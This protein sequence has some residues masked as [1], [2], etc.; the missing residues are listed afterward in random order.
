[1]T[2]GGAMYRRLGSHGVVAVIACLVAAVVVILGVRSVVAGLATPTGRTAAPPDP[3][4]DRAARYASTLASHRQLVDGRSL[5]F[6]PSPPPPPAP[7]RIV[8]DP[9]PPPPPPPPARYGGPAIIAMFDNIVWFDDGKKLHPGETSDAGVKLIRLDAPWSATV[10]WKGVEFTVSF[11]ERDKV[12]VK[13][14]GEPAL[15]GAAAPLT[16]AGSPEREPP[17]PSPA[18]PLEDPPAPPQ[19][20]STAEASRQ[21]QPRPEPDQAP[22]PDRDAPREAEPDPSAPPPSPASPTPPPPPP[23]EE[24]PE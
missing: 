24:S 22:G 17:R 19:G 16:A 18:R 5:F 6:I 1:M 12:V 7:P 8:V 3:T 20:A 2:R 23:G 9:G 10:E 13:P 11:F 4:T 21:G 14:A 15:S